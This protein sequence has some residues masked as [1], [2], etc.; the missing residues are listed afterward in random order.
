MVGVLEMRITGFRAYCVYLYIKKVHYANNSHNIM[1]LHDIPLANRLLGTWNKKR[2]GQDGMK[3]LEI[4]K[5][6]QTNQDLALLYSSYYLNN[7]NFYIQELFEDDFDRF[8]KNK[9]ELKL[10]KNVLT[11]DLECVIIH[12]K[13]NNVTP[14]NIFTSESQIPQ[15]FKM[16]LSWNSLVILNKLFNIVA[17]N[18]NIDINSLEMEAWKNVQIS[19][20]GY[21]Q[22]IQSYLEKHDWKSIAKELLKK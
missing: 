10:L 16:G 7:P 18:E 4:E 17:L 13:S 20:K 21:E 8:R 19:L 22:I 1:N 9:A 2:S 5:Q 11:N 14:I 3:F 15:I 12:I 6:F